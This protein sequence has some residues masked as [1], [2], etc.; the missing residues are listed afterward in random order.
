M[1]ALALSI[2]VCMADLAA[3]V[4]VLC[5]ALNSLVSGYPPDHQTRL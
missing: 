5:A 3:L 1:I 4:L 2:L